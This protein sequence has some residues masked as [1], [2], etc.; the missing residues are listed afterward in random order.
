MNSSLELNTNSSVI[1]TFFVGGFNVLIKLVLCGLFCIQCCLCTWIVCRSW[2]GVL[3]T[4]LC[5]KV[6]KWLASGRWRS[7]FL[8]QY[9][10]PPRYNRNIVESWN[11]HHNP[12]PLND[13]QFYYYQEFN[14]KLRPV[15][16]MRTGSPAE[17]QWH[18]VWTS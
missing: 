15:L 3:D 13:W 7:G 4:T 12:N 18:F 11:K 9:K 2:W 14:L 8:H 5:T 17:D 6:C 10:W 1:W 16:T